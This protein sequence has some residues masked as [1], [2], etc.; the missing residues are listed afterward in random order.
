MMRVYANYGILLRVEFG[1]PAERIESD[2][3]FRDFTGQPIE[4]LVAQV[5]EQARKLRRAPEGFR[6][7]HGRHFGSAWVITGDAQTQA[8]RGCGCHA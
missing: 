7:Q 1:I 4:L 8:R 5:P 3:V 6:R 2:A